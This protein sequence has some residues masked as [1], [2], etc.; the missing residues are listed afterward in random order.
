MINKI[1]IFVILFVVI[2][3]V[4]HADE[5]GMNTTGVVTH[6]D[7][8]WAPFDQYFGWPGVH[9]S[10]N[11]MKYAGMQRLYWRIFNG[12]QVLHNSALDEDGDSVIDVIVQLAYKDAYDNYPEKFGVGK[13]VLSCAV[14]YAHS[15][16]MEIYAWLS[17]VEEQ[18]Y[19]LGPT[20]LF[21]TN[22]PEYREIDRSGRS[23]HGRLSFAFPEVRAYKLSV[24]REVIN[25]Y[26]VDG[27]FLDFARGGLLYDYQEWNPVYDE[28]FTSI[29]G[30][31]TACLSGYQ[32]EYGVGP[33]S[34][35]NNT[36]SWIQYRCDNSWTRFLRDIKAEFPDVPVVCMVF[37]PDA[38]YTR[39]INLLDWETWLSDGLVEGICFLLNNTYDGL[40]FGNDW[41][42]RPGPPSTAATIIQARKQEVAG[43]AE[44]IAGIYCYDIPVD[45][46]AEQAYYAYAGGAD[47]LMWWETGCLVWADSYSGL[48][49]PKVA[50]LSPGYDRTKTI[51]MNDD[52]PVTIA[53]QSL[54]DKAYNLFYTDDLDSEWLDVGG[55]S[56]ILSTA[57]V[58]QWADTRTDIAAATK[59][60]YR[61]ESI[62]TEIISPTPPTSPPPEA[63]EV[64]YSFNETS[65]NIADD[66]SANNRDGT[67][68]DSGAPQWEAGHEGNSLYFDGIANDGTKVTIAGTFPA[69][70]SQIT[71]QAWIKLDEKEVDSEGYD[72][73]WEGPY[74]FMSITK[75]RYL[76]GLIY[77]QAN[78]WVYG[79]TQIPLNTWTHVA[80]V[81][82]GTGPVRT[83]RL[84]INGVGDGISVYTGRAGKIGSGPYSFIVGRNAWPHSWAQRQEFKGWIDDFSIT[85]D[86]VY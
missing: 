50:E 43:R 2:A 39:K 56:K 8:K 60:F 64:Y 49:L 77:D 26:G 72:V 25:D 12:G 16:D 34:I 9:E 67:V 20:S 37:E 45:E 31:D 83:N 78:C 69:G 51:S 36:E 3:G 71:I 80:M 29:F 33:Q 85:Y 19:G 62:D 73:A 41:N 44:V 81:Y 55:Q 75:D 17:I 13:D 5:I 52:G 38:A 28:N 66:T 14:E 1:L 27:I 54:R 10:I 59:R 53:W 79:K 30:Y 58:M 4:V 63:P 48:A 32:D 82:D 11:L 18:H 24:I 46:L 6:S 86:V 57:S 40:M 35:P 42:A 65:G 22:H 23:W 61:L 74:I 7:W 84:L 15:Q 70:P 68:Y 21:V 76:H 47:E